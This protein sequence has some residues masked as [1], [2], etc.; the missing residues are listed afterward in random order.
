MLQKPIDF[1][2]P[3]LLA[4]FVGS[5]YVFKLFAWC[6]ENI[7]GWFVPTAIVALSLPMIL[8]PIMRGVLQGMREAREEE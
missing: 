5:G 4:L 2:F 8:I 7:G 6:G 1:V 3:I